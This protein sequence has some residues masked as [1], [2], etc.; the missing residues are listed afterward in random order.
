MEQRVHEIQQATP[1]E[2]ATVAAIGAG[3][4]L[5]CCAMVRGWDGRYAL[6]PSEGGHQDF[7]FVGPDERCYEKFVREKTG[8][9]SPS[10][11]LIL[12]G[13]GL[14][15]LHLFL[16]GEE[17][18]PIDVA[19]KL[20]AQSEVTQWYGRFYGRA[21]RNYS[22]AVLPFGGLYVCGGIGAKNPFLVDQ[23]A[24]REEF[25]ASP[26]HSELLRRIPIYLN[27]NELSGLWGAAKY[28]VQALSSVRSAK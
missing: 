10:Y 23:V 5:G 15:M 22:L 11:D 19:R 26:I 24:F 7:P 17:I 2:N 27:C 8:D 3:T 13:R 18:S 1:D 20:T 16:H 21:C 4:G 28:A 9:V 25:V 6:M 12:C 14:S